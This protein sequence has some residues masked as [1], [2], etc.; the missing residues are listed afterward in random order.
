MAVEILRIAHCNVNCSD[1]ARSTAFYRDLLGLRVGAHTSPAPQEAPGFGLEGKIQWDAHM[2]HGEAGD[3]VVD[4]LEWKRPRPTG[5]PYSEANHLGMFRICFL[6]PDIGALYEKLRAHD[7]PCLSAP[8]RYAVDP[9]SG[10]EATMFLCRDPDGTVLEFVES[11]GAET[12]LVHANVNCSDLSRSLAWYQRVLGLELR[13]RSR[14]GPSSGDGFQMAGEVEWE[15]AFLV[16]GSNASFLIDLLEWKRPRPVGQPY[17]SANHL[18][19]YRMAFVVEDAH[20]AHED[21]RRNGVECPPP[22]WLDMGPEIP[23]DGLWTVFF[24]DPDG[25]CLELI[26]SPQPVG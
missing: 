26:Q 22:V 9:E 1:L 19:I 12:R 7:V 10:F 6:V 5:T 25:T 2:L 20:A 8:L 17:P 21:L 14:P 4:L 24:P 18:G 13:G 11:E 16:P 3:T 15:A 23:I